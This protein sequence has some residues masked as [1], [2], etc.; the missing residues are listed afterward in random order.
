MSFTLF[1]QSTKG[2][3]E[4]VNTNTVLTFD[5]DWKAT[6]FHDG[7]YE[8][9]FSFVTR[10][11]QLGNPTVNDIVLLNATWGAYANSFMSNNNRQQQTL[12][13]FARPTYL[14][15]T[16]GGYACTL[17]DNVPIRISGKPIQNQFM[18]TIQDMNG[19]LF[20]NAGSTQN[21]FMIYFKAIPR[22]T[23]AITYKPGSFSVQLNS[24]DGMSVGMGALLNGF[25]VFNIDWTNLSSHKGQ[26]EMTSQ[27]SSQAMA[28]NLTV[29][30]TV[31]FD[32]D[33]FSTP[34][35]FAE[36]EGGAPI[37]QMV[38]FFRPTVLGIGGQYANNER[39]NP[40]IIINILPTKNQFLV[41]MATLAGTSAGNFTGN[42]ALTLFFKA[43]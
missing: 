15:N 18:V 26:F 1:L 5:F 42:W 23:Q 4:T 36:L 25:V 13:G 38:G 3:Q 20:A 33:C 30:S 41:S 14:S 40:P 21:I 35:Y 12:L 32:I 31:R 11:A 22:I 16:S 28:N 43:I 27:F 19:N 2:L 37:T 34:T 39:D 10:S 17:Q 6:P 8:V 9:T 7:E 29:F 24:R